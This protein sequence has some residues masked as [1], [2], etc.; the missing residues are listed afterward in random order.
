[1]WVSQEMETCAFLLRA[2][3]EK[4]APVVH[5]EE[6]DSSQFLS[7]KVLQSILISKDCGVW[8]VVVVTGV[9]GR[10]LLML[11]LPE[12]P[13]MVILREGRTHLEGTLNFPPTRWA[14]LEAAQLQ[15]EKIKWAFLA[16]S[17]LKNPCMSLRIKRLSNFG[18]G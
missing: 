3:P 5:P 4:G 15:L 6:L 11:S 9:D 14:G 12:D 17:S 2:E 8:T 18:K 16:Q 13:D 1:M 7:P 10:L